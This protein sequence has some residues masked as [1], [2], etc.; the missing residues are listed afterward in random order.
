MKFR[1]S[2]YRLKSALTKSLRKPLQFSRSRFLLF[3]YPVI[4]CPSLRSPETPRRHRPPRA[5]AAAALGDTSIALLRKG[6]RHREVRE[7]TTDFPRQNP[8]LF[9]PS[10]FFV[11]GCQTYWESSC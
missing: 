11:R 7:A 5:R 6:G 4:P 9:G 8:T 10:R 2:W 1:G 3:V